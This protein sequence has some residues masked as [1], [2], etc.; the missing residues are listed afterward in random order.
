MEKVIRV[1]EQHKKKKI[2]FIAKE[3]VE[4]RLCQCEL[5]M[6]V[7]CFFFLNECGLFLY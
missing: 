7:C 5:C 4:M 6:F 1:M 3:Y 2:N